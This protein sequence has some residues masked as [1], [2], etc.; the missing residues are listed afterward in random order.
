MYVLV[1]EKVNK[2]IELY[3][4]VNGGVN[5]KPEKNWKQKAQKSFVFFCFPSCG[6]DN[7][8][9][10]CFFHT[11]LCFWKDEIGS[12]KSHIISKSNMKIFLRKCVIF[13]VFE[14]NLSG[15]ETNVC[16]RLNA[17]KENYK[18]KT[19]FYVLMYDKYFAFCHMQ[20]R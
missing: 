18:F 16:I 14:H 17:R 19:F 10:W 9:I 6:Q 7:K 15:F 5:I 2:S 8:L 20:I 13:L 1:P 12:L 3:I 11:L 4:I